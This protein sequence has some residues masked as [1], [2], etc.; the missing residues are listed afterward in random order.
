M[1]VPVMI[2]FSFIMFRNRYYCEI[3]YLARLG[4]ISMRPTI[5]RTNTLRDRTVRGWG[6]TTFNKKDY[7]RNLL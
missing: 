3:N 2:D 1:C 4:F 6:L 5:T 7:I